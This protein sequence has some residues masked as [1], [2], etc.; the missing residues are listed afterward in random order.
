MIRGLQW[1]QR[2]GFAFHIA[3]RRRWGDS[4]A[5]MRQG[6]ARVFDEMNIRVDTENPQAFVLFPEI[7]TTSEVPE[8]TTACWGILGVNPSDMMCASSRMV[9]KHKGDDSPSVMACTLLA[10]EHGFNLG[11]S[12]AGASA[13]VALNHP[14]C[15]TF[16]VLGGGSCSV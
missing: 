15:A 14:S 13:P 1:L 16:C 12:L 2:N 3:G 4:E 7:D 6:Y 11:R 10:Y 9:V 8:I 5:E